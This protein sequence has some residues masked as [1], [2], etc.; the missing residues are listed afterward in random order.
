MMAIYG[1]RGCESEK[2]EKISCIVDGSI[3]CEED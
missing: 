2:K 1:L 3:V